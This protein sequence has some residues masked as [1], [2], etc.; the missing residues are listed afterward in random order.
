[1]HAFV[2][3]ISMFPIT[4]EFGYFGRKILCYL[5]MVMSLHYIANDVISLSQDYN[6]CVPNSEVHNT[7]RFQ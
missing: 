5:I 2:V 7:A 4:V 6:R 3:G 1:M